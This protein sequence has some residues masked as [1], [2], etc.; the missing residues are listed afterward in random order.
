M[1]PPDRPSRHKI[2]STLRLPTLAANSR[3]VSRFPVRARLRDSSCAHSP[4]LPVPAMRPNPAVA[5]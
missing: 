1:Q 3:H 4:V 5:S 2:E